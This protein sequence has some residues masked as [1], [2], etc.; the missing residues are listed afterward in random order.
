[1]IGKS[2][3]NDYPETIMRAN[4]PLKKATFDIFS[5]SV[6][7]I[8]G[9]DYAAVITDECTE[10]RWTYGLKTKD[11]MI[12]KAEQW[13]AEI[14]DLRQN[15]TKIPNLSCHARQCWRKCVEENQF[16]FH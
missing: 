1:M 13:F 7:S 2:Q 5:P 11:E 9:Y 8:E 16:F 12:D 3:L 4:L 6:T 15:F 14:A 10:Y